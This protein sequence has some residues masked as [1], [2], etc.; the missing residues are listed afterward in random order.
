MFFV[1]SDKNLDVLR[2]YKTFLSGSRCQSNR[3][4]PE[5]MEQWQRCA[6]GTLAVYFSK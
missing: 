5:G 6:D 4:Q 1:L 2:Y 3:P